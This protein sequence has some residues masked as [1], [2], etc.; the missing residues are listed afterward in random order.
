[1]TD[2]PKAI[3]SNR[4][5]DLL[6]WHIWTVLSVSGTV[7]LLYLN[8]TEF[9]IAGEL[10]GSESSS[11]NLIGL[12]QFVIKAHELAIVASLVAIAHQ[13]I[14]RNLMSGGLLL[15]L[16]GAESSLASPSFLISERYWL[17]LRYGF[18][19]IYTRRGEKIAENDPDRPA[20]LSMLWLVIFVFWGCIIAALAGPASGVLMIPHVDWF[21]HSTHYYQPAEQSTLPNIMIGTA[22]GFLNGYHFSES[23]VFALPEKI[24]GAPLQYWEDVSGR[25]LRLPRMSLE[26]K[27]KHVFH[28]IFGSVFVNT[29][30]SYGRELD[31]QWSGGTRIMTSARNVYFMSL[32][33]GSDVQLRE[34]GKGWTALKSMDT[35]H[36]LDAWVTCRATEKRPCTENAVLSGD[37]SDPDWCYQSVNRD[38]NNAGTL[39][40]SQNL[41]MAH[42]FIEGWN[43]PRVWLTE[44]PRI[45][46][47][48][49]YSDSIEVLFEKPAESAPFMFNLTVC[50][51]SAELVAAIGTSYGTDYT[52]E[53]VKYFDYIL[54]PDGK[55]A[56][57]RKFLFHEN[58]LDRAYSYDPELWTSLPFT[59]LSFPE[60]SVEAP[61]NYTYPIGS[62][63]YPDNFTYPARPGMDPKM[64]LFGIFAS[65]L[66][67]AVGF[68]MT[69]ESQS[70]QREAFPVEATVGGMLAYL[71]S[72]SIPC[73]SQYSMLYEEIPERFR[74]EPPQ[75]YPIVYS[76]EV[77]RQGYGF[78]LSTRTAYLGVTILLS[79]AVIAIAASLWQGM[80]GGV[81]RAWTTIPD[82]AILGSGSPSLVMAYP[83]ACAGV[84]GTNVLAGLIQVAEKIPNSI[85]PGAPPQQPIT[86]HLEIVAVNYSDKT[87]TNPVDL[88]NTKKKYGALQQ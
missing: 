5:R 76:W 81:I 40:T 88:A 3:V 39:R 87:I 41:L 43:H 31:G 77:Y 83:N 51:F 30:G 11:R 23:N 26:D 32:G 21:Y 71:L 58:W 64:N 67:S 80:R 29:T 44:G 56:K 52:A 73:E 7:I 18:R 46:S 24:I 42:D 28:D 14:L 15:G 16:L 61:E 36:G 38:N 86:P 57:P 85:P 4:L 34:I 25:D 60:G 17:A 50:S 27:S 2:E 20:R 8:F 10:G 68:T 53:K 75:S 12:L 22:G 65:H 9:A 13:W 59:N 72:W 1:M 79:H 19:G 62:M 47:N 78:R 48:S 70:E 35:T 45:E 33:N 69:P 37:A 55:T 49:H 6:L 74:L 82:Y 63:A 84:A 54:L 66:T